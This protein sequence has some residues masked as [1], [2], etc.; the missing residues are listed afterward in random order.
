MDLLKELAD[1][2][3][4]RKGPFLV[5]PNIQLKI[6]DLLNSNVV[7]LK[8]VHRG[9]VVAIIGDFDALSLAT[10]LRLIDLSVTVV[11][12]TAATHPEHEYFFEAAAVDVVIEGGVAKRRNASWGINPLLTK[13]RQSGN[14][15]LVLFSSGTTG[16]PKAILH[17]FS[18]FLAR[19]RTP[20]PT[21]R[22]LNFLL[23]DHIGG[24]NTF[25]HTIFN[26]GQVIAPSGRTPQSVISDI[27]D[28]HVELLP[29]TPTF[30]RMMLLEGELDTTELSSLRVITYGTER[31]DQSTLDRLCKTL[32]QIDFRQ[33]YG[34]SELG[35]L[36]VKS[37]AR[38][39]LW[40]TVG[41]EGVEIRTVGGVLHIR[42]ANRMLGYLNAPS[43]FDAEGWYDTG[44]IV[45]QDGPY[46]KVIGRSKEVINVGGVKILPAEL[47]R[48]ALLHPDVLLAKARGVPNPI[49]GQHIEITCQPRV[50]AQLNRQ[51]LRAHFCQHLSEHSRP[52]F[53]RIGEIAVSHRFKQE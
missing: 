47:E 2:N 12:L 36:R 45:E 9:D 5:G 24:I 19:Y 32:P 11:P 7:D 39:S 35:I 34:M 48:V 6:D 4:S 1:R 3:A 31:M 52:Q 53:I 20:R 43:P 50:G 10:L 44:D 40:M 37:R 18:C 14:P 8:C 51:N 25:F 49:T 28:R 29:T 26:G 33:T 38:D 13:L 22:T 46:I 16:R 23:F 30:L 21:Y 27:H 15:G 41:G 42:S 17:D